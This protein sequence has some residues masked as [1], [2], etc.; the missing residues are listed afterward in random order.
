MGLYGDACSL[1]QSP[2]PTVPKECDVFR[3]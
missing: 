1:G 2:S 3:Q